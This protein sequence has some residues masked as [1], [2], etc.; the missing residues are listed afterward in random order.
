MKG[1]GLLVG[2][3]LIG[4]LGSRSR[5]G[6][7][8]PSRGVKMEVPQLDGQESGVN[9]SPPWSMRRSTL[10]PAAVRTGWRLP[11]FGGV[12]IARDRI[13][14]SHQQESVLFPRR[15]PGCSVT[16]RQSP[17]PPPPPSR[18][19]LGLDDGTDSDIK[20]GAPERPLCV[21]CLAQPRMTCLFR[22]F[23]LRNRRH[24]VADNGRNAHPLPGTRN[25]NPWV[26]EAMPNARQCN[27]RG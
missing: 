10:G 21:W 18:F 12:S 3:S 14:S 2:R 8:V 16:R 22:K 17:P 20:F 26:Q 11:P 1:V 19:E 13:E 27:A 9:P 15:R 5:E 23:R 7:G 24:P 25:D 4:G 6:R